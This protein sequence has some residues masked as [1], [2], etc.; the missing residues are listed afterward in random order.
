MLQRVTALQGFY[1]F[2]IKEE[3]KEGHVEVEEGKAGP[4]S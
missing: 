4:G 2:G 3:S 1:A